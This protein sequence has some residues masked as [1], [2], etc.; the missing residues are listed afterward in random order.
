MNNLITNLTLMFEKKFPGVTRAQQIISMLGL[1]DVIN[2]YNKAI[3]EAQEEV[4]KYIDK[5]A[6]KKP[7]NKEF[8][9]SENAVERGIYADLLRNILGTEKEQNNEFQRKLN[10]LF[11]STEA[12]L[13]SEN[14]KE[15]QLGQ[16]Y[17][18]VIDKLGLKSSYEQYQKD[19]NSTHDITLNEIEKNV[20][21]I[22]KDAVKYWIDVY[23]KHYEALSF[24]S[25]SVYN[26]VL[27]P[28]L[29]Y[30][31]VRYRKLDASS[32]SFKDRQDEILSKKG[33]FYTLTTDTEKS[34][35]LNKTTKPRRL[36][37]G[38]YISYDFDLNNSEILKSALIDINT[39]IPI[40]KFSGA[41]QSKYFKDIMGEKDAQ[42]IAT[43]I[44]KYIKN[45]KGKNMLTAEEERYMIKIASKISQL[46]TE[47]VLGGTVTTALKQMIP[48]FSNT[49]A[50]A[51]TYAKHIF[52]LKNLRQTT[53]WINKTG[54]EIA[55]RGQEAITLIDSID[56]TIEKEL[57][58]KKA[59]LLEKYGMISKMYL[60]VFLSNADLF[61][62][63]GAF[64]SYYIQDLNR[65]GIEFSYDGEMNQESLQYAQSMVSRQ[66]QTSDKLLQG[67]LYQT[68][69]GYK[70]IMARLIMPFSNFTMNLKSRVYADIIAL[71]NF[72]SLSET[73]RRISIK[74]MIGTLSE[75]GMFNL[76]SYGI[77]ITMDEIA[78]EI[79]SA[80]GD[81]DDEDK[82]VKEEL[83]KA[84][85]NRRKN[86]AITN[87]FMDIASPL[88]MLD[89]RIID[90]TNYILGSDSSDDIKDFDETYKNLTQS[91][92]NEFDV[93]IVSR[94]KEKGSELT[95][96][97][98]LK[99]IKS[100]IKNRSFGLQN[101][102]SDDYSAY[103]LFG[104]AGKTI[105][106]ATN[107]AKKLFSNE[108]EREGY[109]GK[110]KAYIREEDEEAK[111]YANT[112]ILLHSIGLLPAEAKS[113]GNRMNRTVEKRAYNEKQY[114]KI[115]FLNKNVGENI[116][117]SKIGV[118][119]IKRE[120]LTPKMTYTK[121]AGKKFKTEDIIDYIYLDGKISSDKRIELLNKLE[122]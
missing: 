73:D 57:K 36:N 37:E 107:A 122:D 48:M 16:T 14:K 11:E 18:K 34:G 78:D 49:L 2:G 113:I 46:S 89:D 98:K 39:A 6:K 30:N 87:F 79:M 84:R 58:G 15:N 65:K 104:A 43:R 106:D 112:L 41:K 50:T 71:R 69:S 96:D 9:N 42:T 31:P 80:L 95:K 28:E 64:M 26:S 29:N 68:D 91:D 38:S 93:L 8:F 103:G 76:L 90:L 67:S 4:D 109:G 53:E 7:N 75:I 118:K 19:N 70:Y 52:D 20:D 51:G 115:V 1:S 99:L 110:E 83:K 24:I 114:D 66:Q 92:K 77:W 23:S 3:K 97:Q 72:N 119:T 82:S 21:P 105:V 100:F 33:S 108:I 102:M 101:R 74:S 12:L 54:M 32:G 116:M 120:N 81:D 63:R 47:R 25:Q 121:M 5:F 35:T 45:I 13:K 40:R 22:N 85:E 27:S 117:N 111:K 62:A 59:N 60:R 10:L 88:P 61:A 55:N 44:D 94:E 56:N 86:T 17:Q